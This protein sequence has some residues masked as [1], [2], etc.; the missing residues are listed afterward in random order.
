[1]AEDEGTTI[2]LRA[3]GKTSGPIPADEFGE[4]LDRGIQNLK[5]GK[6]VLGGTK[7]GDKPLSS[8]SLPG[9]LLFL[10]TKLNGAIDDVQVPAEFP[11][12]E[13]Y[14][15]ARQPK[16]IADA[17]IPVL[18]AHLKEARIAFLFRK[19]MK[20]H[21]RTVWGKATRPGA[22]WRTLSGLDYVVEFNWS[23]WVNLTR[24]ERVRLVDH[25]LEHCAEV[26]NEQTGAMEFGTRN[27]D[28]EEFTEIIR[29]WGIGR[30]QHRF[31]EA[32]QQCELFGAGSE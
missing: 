31:A 29:R 4:R 17:I 6:T 25:E 14:P 19:E 12:S 30:G 7:P 27:H 9:P 28:V 10:A 2:E 32:V 15:V 5:E 23:M 1:M 8:E 26:E 20:K 24:R 18:H 21:G 11:E 16:A 22:K 3:G 13:K